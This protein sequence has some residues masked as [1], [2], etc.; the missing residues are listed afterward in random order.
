MPDDP[1][2]S[3]DGYIP[4]IL[5]SVKKALGIQES[6][7]HFD[8]DI[9]MHINATLAVLFQLGVGPQDTPVK[10]EDASYTWKEFVGDRNDL[11]MVQ[12]QMFIR[13]KQL[14]DPPTSSHVA[15]AMKETLNELDWRSLVAAEEGR[16]D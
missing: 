3:S 6:Y 9:L 1:Q 16:N 15:T 12:D 10:I 7:T 5:T 11:N 14:F 4:S 8:A 2:E 13:V